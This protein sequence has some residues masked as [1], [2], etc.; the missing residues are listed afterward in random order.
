MDYLVMFE[1]EVS[2][3]TFYTT[4]K[5]HYSGLF[6]CSKIMTNLLYLIVQFEV[7]CINKNAPSLRSSGHHI[8]I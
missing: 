6:E 8:I 7:P 4:N 2:A 5:R 1:I 3:K